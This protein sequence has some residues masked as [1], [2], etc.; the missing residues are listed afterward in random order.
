[1]LYSIYI[2]LERAAPGPIRDKILLKA[3]KGSCIH[4]II[5]GKQTKF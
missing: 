4:G 3:Q 2:Y 1:M 5:I